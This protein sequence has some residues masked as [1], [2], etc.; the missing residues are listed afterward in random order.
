MFMRFFQRFAQTETLLP[1][2]ARKIR[3]NIFGEGNRDADRSVCIGYRFGNLNYN[4][5][6]SAKKFLAARPKT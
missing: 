3:W 6:S 5:A 1:D 4:A 2:N